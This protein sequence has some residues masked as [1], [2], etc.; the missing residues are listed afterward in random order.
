MWLVRAVSFR[1]SVGLLGSILLVFSVTTVGGAHAQDARRVGNEPIAY[2]PDYSEWNDCGLR[3]GPFDAFVTHR[4]SVEKD[5]EKTASIGVE[6]GSDVPPAAREAYDRAVEIWEHHVASEVEIRIRVGKIEDADEST[7]GGTIPTQFWVVERQNGNRFIAGGALTDALTGQDAAP[8]T[9][10]MLT[11]FNLDRNDWHFGEGEAPSGRIDFTSVALHEIAHG[12][13]YL[14]LCRYNINGGQ[15]KFDASD[16]GPVPGVFTRELFEQRPDDSLAA[17][18]DDQEYPTAEALGEALTSKR[19]VFDGGRA[20]LGAEYS[21]GPIPPKI[22]A[23]D[24]FEPGSSISHLDENTYPF[25][26]R[27][28]LM[29]PRIA[30]AETNRSPGPVVCG[31]L[32]DLGWSLGNS[33]L[34]HFQDV[35]NLRFAEAINPTEAGF[36][37]TWEVRDEAEIDEYIVER[38][39]FDGSFEPIKDGIDRP[40]VTIDSLGLGRFSFRVRW[41]NEDGTESVSARRLNTTINVDDFS[42]EV[43]SRDEQGRGTVHV[44][45]DVPSA[46]SSSFTYG[47]ERASGS[48]EAFH[49]VAMGTAKQF[50]AEDQLPGQYSYRVVSRDGQGNRLVSST[51]PVEVRF[52]GVVYVG[53][54]FPNPSRDQATV[55]LTAR[56]PQGVSVDVYNTLGE[57]IFSGTEELRPHDPVRISLDSRRWSSGMY[58]LRISGRTFSETRKMVV[59]Q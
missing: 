53:G 49:E 5:L 48:G 7:L 39:Y 43:V 17:L 32:A 9:V 57:R 8:D 18:T 54:P 13:H 55:T 12:F 36:T 27:N 42:A 34:Q 10:D 25:E 59:V 47:L 40:P 19:V 37:L 4:P 50:Q 26:G 22:Y 33:C 3:K 14:S 30:P 24:P 21:A 1:S 58:F 41:V 11:D 56:D 15:C 52:D 20:G 16:D 6:Y 31:Q 23:P 38:R 51:V 28:A 2:E 35:Y 29:T 46:T 45:W 44:S